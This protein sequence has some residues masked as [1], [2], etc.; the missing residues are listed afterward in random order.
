MCIQTDFHASMKSACTH[1]RVNLVF[2]HVCKLRILRQ[3]YK[4]HSSDRTVS[5]LRDD[6]LGDTFHLGV[7]VIV[8]V[9]VY[10][11]YYVG[12]LLDRSGFSE[13]GEHRSVVRTLL[14]GSGQL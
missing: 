2:L 5:L 14:H 9:T 6:D 13:V 10:E 11:H 1:I 4:V 7:M 8:I 3:P 12:I